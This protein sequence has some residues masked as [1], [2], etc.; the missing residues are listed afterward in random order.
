VAR[1]GLVRCRASGP[2]FFCCCSVMT[3]LGLPLF[4]QKG[5]AEA[6]KG[7]FAKRCAA[8]HGAQVKERSAR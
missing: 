7:V 1:T 3:A 4:G 5:D 2:K 6:G 8:C